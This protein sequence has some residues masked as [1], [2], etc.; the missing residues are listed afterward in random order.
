LG[1]AGVEV[2][3]DAPEE[4]ALEE[5]A[6]LAPGVAVPPPHAVTASAKAAPAAY[7]AP[8]DRVIFVTRCSLDS[9]F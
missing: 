4:V 5:A 9:A 2:L 8:L 6:G 7:E 1:T 3:E